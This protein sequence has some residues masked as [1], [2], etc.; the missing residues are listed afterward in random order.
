MGETYKLINVNDFNISLSFKMPA[1]W[2]NMNIINIW[3][4]RNK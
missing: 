3:K 1:N 4:R 2:Q